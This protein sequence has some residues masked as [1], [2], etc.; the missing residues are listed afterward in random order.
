MASVDVSG[1]RPGL[2]GA[3]G[4]LSLLLAL[5]PGCG[6]SG[7]ADSDG[8]AETEAAPTGGTGETAAGE[9]SPTGGETEGAAADEFQPGTPVLP[10]LT[11]RQYLNTVEHLF[12]PGLPIP[13]LEADTN[14]YLFYN[15]GAASTTL[16]ELG[17]QQYEEAANLI[18]GFV[19]ADPARRDALVGCVPAAPGDPCVDGFIAGFGRRAYRRPLTQEERVRWVTVATELAEGDAWRGLQLAVAGMLQSP[20]FLYRVELGEPDPEDSSRRR[21]TSHEMASRLSFLLWN[22]TPDD[23]L[24]AAADSGALVTEAG[25]L[26]QAARMID[27]PRARTAVQAFFAQYFDLGRLDGATRDPARYP[28][29]TPTLTR[30]MRTEVELLV[31]DFVYRRDADIRGILGTRQ[32]FVNAELAA[33]YGVDAPGATPVTFVP[34]ELPADGHRKGLL[35]LG[36]YLT[37]NAHETQNSPTARGKYIRERL[38]CQDVPAPPGDIDLNLEEDDPA[39]PT[40][41]REKLKAHREN[42]ACAGC[43]AFTDPPGLLFENFDPIG[44]YRTLDNGFP[45]DSS[46]ELDGVPLANG[47]ELAA[48]LEDNVEVGRCLVRQLYRHAT[49]RREQFPAELPELNRLSDDFA[50]S[51]YRFRELLLL[52]ITSEAFR[53]VAEVEVGP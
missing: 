20:Y 43:H 53:T 47:R 16:S 39:A 22:T 51:G 40:T 52:L 9:T 1:R 49:G 33:L 42:P 15:I 17:A 6:D 30:S 4:A 18:A 34:V 35:T 12:G 5:G 10:R 31:D 19:F 44:A 21:Y 24:L 13:A 14:P 26:D 45:I 8:A 28:L 41:L 29:Y 38:L 3:L 37:M 32:T 25:L 27:D 11:Q 23:A 7:R 48:L 2:G 50:A 36:A 46:G